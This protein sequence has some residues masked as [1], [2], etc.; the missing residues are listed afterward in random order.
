MEGG[1]FHRGVFWVIDGVLSAYPFAEG[2]YAEGAARSG[3]TYHHQKL[4]QAVQLLSPRQGGR[5][6]QGSA[7]DLHEPPRI[8]GPAVGDTGGVWHHVPAAAPIRQQPPLQ[9]PSG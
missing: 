6:Q 7:G 5:G 2:V 8:A 9:M 3:A 1:K 4:W